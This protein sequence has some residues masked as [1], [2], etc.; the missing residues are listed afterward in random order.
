MGDLRP[1]IA[2]HFDTDAGAKTDASSYARI[3]HEVGLK[4][5]QFVFFS[6]TPLELTAAR[7]AGVQSFHVVKED[8][9]PDPAFPALSQFSQVELV[10]R[11]EASAVPQ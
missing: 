6:D 9:K 8:T 2:R 4:P 10:R 7:A 3:A 1:L 5:A 11:D